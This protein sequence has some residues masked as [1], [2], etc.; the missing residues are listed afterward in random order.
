MQHLSKGYS[1][2]FNTNNVNL[3]K[4]RGNFEIDC[5]FFYKIL[6]FINIL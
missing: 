3:N 1:T 6:I 4:I 2:I 5:D